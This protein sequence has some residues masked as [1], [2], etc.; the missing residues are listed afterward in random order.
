M[1]PEYLA[2]PPISC[3]PEQMLLLLPVGPDIARGRRP[4][5][6]VVDH[7]LVTG[8]AAS[9]TNPTMFS[10]LRKDTQKEKEEV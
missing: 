9:C 10:L 3:S 1:M 7:V 4:R 6:T 5:W 8:L 2:F